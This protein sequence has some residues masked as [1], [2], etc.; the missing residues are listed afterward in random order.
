MISDHVVQEMVSEIGDSFKARIIVMR[1]NRRVM[2]CINVT[3]YEI[4][5]VAD[6]IDND[7]LNGN[8]CGSFWV[9]KSFDRT[10]KEL[11]YY[12]LVDSEHSAYIIA[13]IIAIR[14]SYFADA[15]DYINSLDSIYKKAIEGRQLDYKRILSGSNAPCNDVMVAIDIVTDFPLD[16]AYLG[17][18]RCDFNIGYKEA[19]LVKGIKEAVVV[20][21]GY[22]G[23]LDDFAKMSEYH[24][25]KNRLND[26]YIG[27]G[28]RVDNWTRLQYS[29]Q[30]ASIVISYM[31][32]Y[33]ALNR[34]NSY[35]R[36]GLWHL[37]YGA[38]EHVK[39]EFLE[40]VFKTKDFK[41]LNLEEIKM[42]S[43]YISSDF[44]MAATSAKWHI[45]RKTLKKLVIK[46][47]QITGYDLSSF[48]DAVKF[49]IASSMVSAS[50]RIT[51][52]K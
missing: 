39:K 21:R 29:Y 33:N 7:E 4:K 17:I 48:N 36:L 32:R 24:M 13:R 16:A 11:K 43:D 34:I 27:I 8:W 26:I 9:E 19:V 18:L 1:A 10:N 37:Y 49:R 41:D 28:G 51:A 35:E 30:S 47:S 46:Y 25:K 3:I 6:E 14:M 42:V 38:E 2:A 23:Y 52:N 31:R 20:K 22:C 12:I 44:N 15:I 50:S 45:N 5:H 40:E